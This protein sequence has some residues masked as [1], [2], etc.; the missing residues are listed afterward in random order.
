MRTSNERIRTLFVV[1]LL[2]L[3]VRMFFAALRGDYPGAGISP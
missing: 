3:A 1:V 2:A